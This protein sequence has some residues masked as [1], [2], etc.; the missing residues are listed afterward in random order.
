MSN[1]KVGGNSNLCYFIVMHDHHHHHALK[2]ITRALFLNFIFVII[3][4]VGAYFSGSMAVFADA[5]HDIGDSLTLVIAW[6]LQRAS[7]KKKNRQFTYGYGRLSL[8]SSLVVGGIL[9]L[10]SLLIIWHATRNFNTSRVLHPEIMLPLSI[11]GIIFNGWAYFSLRHGHSHNE[12]AVGLHM[13]E[14]LLGWVA[15]GTVSISLFFVNWVWLDPLLAIGIAFFTLYNAFRNISE[16]TR[17]FLQANPKDFD[18]E[19]YFEKVKSVTGVIAAH[20]IHVWSLDG[21]RHVIS[22]HL[23]VDP[24]HSLDE[25]ANIK[26]KCR[27]LLKDFGHFHCTIETETGAI[28]S[29]SISGV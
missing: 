11:L 2:N 1:S 15:V 3:E 24:N 18:L 22:Y 21:H 29:L 23:Q 17:V 4:L 9:V 14:D 27:G 6:V 19:S 12:K 7:L 26:N 25:I 20:D 16:S 10:G 5:L 8:V 13:L 28:A